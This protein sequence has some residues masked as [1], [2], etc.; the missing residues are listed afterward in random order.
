MNPHTIRIRVGHG[1]P[2]VV[3]WPLPKSKL[4]H[5]AWLLFSGIIHDRL[6]AARGAFQ[7]H[8]ADPF[9]LHPS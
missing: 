6:A 7:M 1:V 3:V 2:G 8:S 5:L 9:E 4:K